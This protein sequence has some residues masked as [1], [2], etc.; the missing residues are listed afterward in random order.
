MKTKKKIK[1][2]NIRIQSFVTSLSHDERK[3]LKG[4]GIPFSPIWMCDPDKETD[5]C[6]CTVLNNNCETDNCETNTCHCYTVVDC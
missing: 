5:T 2:E 3:R 6:T 1:L 4:G